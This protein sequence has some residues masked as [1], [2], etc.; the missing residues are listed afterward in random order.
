MTEQELVA[1]ITPADQE[2]MAQ[3]SAHW[4]SIAKPLHGLGR[5]EDLIV[6]AAGGAGTWNLTMDKKAVAVFCADNGV[7]AQ[8]VTQA[9]PGVTLEVAKALGRNRSSVCHMARTA[10]AQV[11]PVDVGMI[12]HPPL[13]GVQDRSLMPGTWDISQGPA[14]TRETAVQAVAVGV[15]TALELA[16]Q[17]Y[18]LLAAGEMGIGNTTTTAAV[19]AAL[20]GLSP[21]ETVGRGAGLSDQGLA[22]K[23][24]AVA[25]ALEVNAPD[26]QDPMDIICKVGGLDIAAMAGFYL[27]CAKAQVP[28]L[29]DGAIS[30]AAALLAVRLCSQAKKVLLPGHWPLEPSGRLLL[31]ALG[32]EPVLDAQLHLGEGTGA[33]AAMPLLDMAL[34]IYREMSSFS[35]MGL[36]AY[37]EDGEAVSG[38]AAPEEVSC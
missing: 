12:P 1:G 18:N 8:G 32:L 19:T 25:R 27:G 28:V 22:R 20:L 34:S 21:E 37:R 35:G 13:P 38:P 31:K 9:G 29:L 36:S 7:V 3:A 15:E 6:R 17:G 4:N 11:V 30:C 16:G 23:R 2:S 33:V 5:L 10:G 26:G 14:M 24:W